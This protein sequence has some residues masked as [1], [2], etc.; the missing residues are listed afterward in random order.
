MSLK[1][2]IKKILKEE[3]DEWVD[4]DAEDYNDLLK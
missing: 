4:V 3:T 2:V 1:Y